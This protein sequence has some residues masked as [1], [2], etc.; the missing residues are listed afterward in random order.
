[1]LLIT[2][3][4]LFLSSIALPIS[5]F[6]VSNIVYKLIDDVSFWFT[7][8]SLLIPW[9]PVYKLIHKFLFTYPT[10]A[11]KLCS[12][13]MTVSVIFGR[14]L[15]TSSVD[16]CCFQL[17]FSNSL[18]SWDYVPCSFLPL[19]LLMPDCMT[20]VREFFFFYWWPKAYQ[21]YSLFHFWIPDRH[22]YEMDTIYTYSPPLYQLW[23]N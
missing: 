11:T 19:T 20:S 3:F 14:F 15:Y 5:S 4:Q 23:A 16:I 6:S 12:P 7:S 8:W 18:N 13:F 2:S 21:V 9:I 17:T 22:N 1:M 10:L